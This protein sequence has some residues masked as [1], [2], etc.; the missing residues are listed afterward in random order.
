MDRHLKIFNA[1]RGGHQ[2]FRQ[3]CPLIYATYHTPV[4]SKFTIGTCL[5]SPREAEM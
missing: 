4:D 5:T 1:K 2:G 3:A